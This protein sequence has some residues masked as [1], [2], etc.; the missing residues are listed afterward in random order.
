MRVRVLAISRPIARL[1]SAAVREYI[2]E[3]DE[4]L[5]GPI[6]VPNTIQGGNSV[7]LTNTITIPRVAGLRGT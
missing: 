1:Q 3:T 7:D 5:T 2:G 4:L 6:F